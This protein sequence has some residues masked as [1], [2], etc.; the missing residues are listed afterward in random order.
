M[1]QYCNG[2][3]WVSYRIVAAKIPFGVA[4]GRYSVS[5]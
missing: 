3:E 4:H 2:V 5:S 1:I